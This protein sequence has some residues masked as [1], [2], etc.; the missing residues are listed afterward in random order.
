M[1]QVKH[2]PHKGRGIIATQNITKGT[3]LEVAPVGVIPPEKQT[4]N[5]K[6]VFKY[7]FVRPSEYNEGQEVKAYYLIFG[8]V[9]F[10]NHSQ[11]PNAH[12][13]WT[14]NEDG[15]WSNLICQQDIQ[16]GEEVTLFYTNIG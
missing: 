5:P 1:I 10:C 9:S 15:I 16:E 12:V 8:L 4:M 7:Y 13:H 2:I 6:G 14:E 11:E 3:V